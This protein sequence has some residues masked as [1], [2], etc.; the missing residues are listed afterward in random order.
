MKI[1]YQ[2]IP[3]IAAAARRQRAREIHRLIIAPLLAFFKAPKPR[4]SRMSRSKAY[5]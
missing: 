5:C 2:K 4:A 3:E 1:D